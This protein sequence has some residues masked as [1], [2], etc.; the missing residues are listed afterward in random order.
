MTL[1]RAEPALDLTP[2]PASLSCAVLSQ[3]IRDVETVSR[4][5]GDGLNRGDSLTA[6]PTPPARCPRRNWSDAAPMSSGVTTCDLTSRDMSAST[7]Q[8][9]RPLER[10]AECSA[11]VWGLSFVQL[12]RGPFVAPAFTNIYAIYVP[13]GPHQPT[14]VL[15]FVCNASK[16]CLPCLKPGLACHWACAAA[17]CVV[18][19]EVAAEVYAICHWSASAWLCYI[20][21]DKSRSAVRPCPQNIATVGRTLFSSLVSCHALVHATTEA[22][23]LHCRGCCDWVVT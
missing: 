23:D 19:A 11:M 22:A 16:T 6:A 8:F 5:V 9:L 12:C 10:P 17:F 18:G 14:A 3:L 20:C 21:A 4:I 7:V 1:A 2:W 13:C 15:P